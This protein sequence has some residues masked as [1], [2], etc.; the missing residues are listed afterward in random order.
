[1]KMKMTWVG[2]PNK[3]TA[4]LKNREGRCAMNDCYNKLNNPPS[5]SALG[6]KVCDK[7][8]RGDDQVNKAIDDIVS[9]EIFKEQA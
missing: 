4:T 8:F 5:I 1:M 3:L 2:E 9:R 6:W 7:C